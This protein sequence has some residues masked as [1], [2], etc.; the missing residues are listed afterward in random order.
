MGRRILSAATK[1]KI[2][3]SLKGNKNAYSG[4]PKRVNKPRKPLSTRQKVANINAAAKK[5]KMTLSPDQIERRRKVAQRLRGIARQ[6]EAGISPAHSKPIPKPNRPD[7]ADTER[8]EIRV[9]VRGQI[10][11]A[12]VKNNKGPMHLGSGDQFNNGVKQPKSGTNSKAKKVAKNNSGN[13]VVVGNKNGS[14]TVIHTDANTTVIVNRSKSATVAKPKTTTGE[15]SAQ[16]RQR[17]PEVVSAA[18]QKAASRAKPPAD[19]LAKHGNPKPLP[20]ASALR[21]LSTDD[22]Q[23]RIAKSTNASETKKLVNEFN[24]RMGITYEPMKRRPPRNATKIP[25]KRR[26]TN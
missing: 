20:T 14:T 5:K 18:E 12:T 25:K 4:G 3:A 26:T 9:R 13:T 10:K 15:T 23:D 11:G 16:W 8:E 21:S 24:L 1:A 22:L 2:S 17:N 6:E 7:P 19:P